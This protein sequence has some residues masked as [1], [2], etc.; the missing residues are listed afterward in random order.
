MCVDSPGHE[1]QNILKKKEKKCLK[2]FNKKIRKF[3]HCTLRI[4]LW[5]K[6]G[7]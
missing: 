7:V 2:T 4:I 6:I 1:N 3:I 5:Q